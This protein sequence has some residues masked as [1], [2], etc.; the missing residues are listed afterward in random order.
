MLIC[1]FG[2]INI[3]NSAAAFSAEELPSF[4]LVFNFINVKSSSLFKNE[5]MLW[6]AVVYTVLICLS[7]HWPGSFPLHG[8]LNLL[9]SQGWADGFPAELSSSWVRT[10]YKTLPKPYTALISYILFKRWQRLE[11]SPCL[12]WSFYQ[13]KTLTASISLLWM[14]SHCSHL[15]QLCSSIKYKW[16]FKSK[17]MGENRVQ[18]HHIEQGLW[19]FT[20]VQ[21][22]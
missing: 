5:L 3:K 17:N 16:D 20:E 22:L 21:R 15:M 4:F 11:K 14:W 10:Y 19:H 9:V 6:W 12:Q 7:H 2:K 1:S 18:R 8:A 13:I